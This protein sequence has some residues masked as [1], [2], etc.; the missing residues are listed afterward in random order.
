MPTLLTLRQACARALDDL[1]TYTVASA[2]AAQIATG[3]VIN[4]STNA[5]TE[6]YNA[7]WVY[8]NSGAAA[9]QQR[10]VIRSSY[11]P[12]T[13]ALGVTPNWAVIP[14]TGQTFE[15]TS[16]F[17]SAPSTLGADSDY[18]SL[19]NRTLD[20]LYF[21][22]TDTV[23]IATSYTNLTADQIDW[24]TEP[25]QVIRWTEASPVVNRAKPDASW[26]GIRLVLDPTPQVEVLAPTSGDLTLE[27]WRPSDTYISGAASSV[28]LTADADVAYVQT[29]DV[30]L[31]FLMLAYE[32]LANRQPG[33]PS[34]PWQAKRAAQLVL[35][36]SEHAQRR[37]SGD[38][39]LEMAAA[40]AQQ[41]AA[42]AA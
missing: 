24:L 17:P 41:Q 39:T 42:R 4:T 29:R 15:M 9:G 1:E 26:R 31:V 30:V 40:E 36:Q 18:R 32:V 13:G 27:A 28:G 10:Q 3:Q 21:R 35:I 34:G 20:L 23:T 12:S 19:I 22:F 2:A 11:V 8:V 16:L 6:R 14:I 5:S 38:R 33:R 25:D 37:E 7:R